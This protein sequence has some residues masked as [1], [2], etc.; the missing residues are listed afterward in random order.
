MERNAQPDRKQTG[1]ATPTRSIRKQTQVLLV[2]ILCGECIFSLP[3]HIGRYFRPLLLDVLEL[4]NTEL[5]DAFAL[6]GVVAM[7]S[8][9]PGGLI[10]DRFSSRHLIALS[11]WATAAGG[12]VLLTLPDPSLLDE[13]G[14]RKVR[15]QIAN[16]VDG[17]IEDLG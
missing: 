15:D 11:M 16:L 10:A 8:Y 13:D 5:G 7:A 2:L 9:F 12:C 4:T 17:L 3:F 1:L 14:V 6:Y